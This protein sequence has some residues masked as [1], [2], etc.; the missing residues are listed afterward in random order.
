LDGC[1]LTQA[2]LGTGANNITWQWVASSAGTTVGGT[3]GAI[4]PNSNIIPLTG[5]WLA[6]ETLILDLD[7]TYNGVTI[8]KTAAVT[9]TFTA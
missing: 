6:N 5:A 9:V 8:T 2:A 1:P 7:L 4:A 3:T